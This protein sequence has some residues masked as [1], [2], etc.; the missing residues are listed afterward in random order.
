MVFQVPVSPVQGPEPGGF[1]VVQAGDREAGPVGT[2][3]LAPGRSAFTDGQMPW[4]DVAFDADLAANVLGDLVGT[5]T[6]YAGD[7]ELGKSAVAL[8]S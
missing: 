3:V 6:L 8:R 1:G 2:E 4:G 5:P 7:V